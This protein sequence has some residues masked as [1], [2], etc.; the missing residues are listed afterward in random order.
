M[1]LQKYL[2]V[3]GRRHLQARDQRTY[4]VH[5]LTTANR[6]RIDEIVTH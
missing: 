4:A 5:Q 1:K 2:S 6:S 3:V